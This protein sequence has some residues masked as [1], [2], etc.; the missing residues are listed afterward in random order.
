M[1]LIITKNQSK[2]IIG[3]VSFEVFAKI[4]LSE[5][6]KKLI[7]HY[8]LHNEI[9][10]QKKMV[11]WGEPTDHLIDVRVKHLVDGTTYKCKNLGEVLGY[12]NSLKEACATLKTYLEVAKSFGGE[13]WIEY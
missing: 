3:G 2:G 10:F 1:K 9:L 6:E 11:I 7:D 5:E 13:E 12:I 8:K 4:Q